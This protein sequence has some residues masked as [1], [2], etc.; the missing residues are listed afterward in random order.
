MALPTGKRQMSTDENHSGWLPLRFV[1]TISGLL[2]GERVK[3][4]NDVKQLLHFLNQE[5]NVYLDTL[6]LLLLLSR[7]ITSD[8]ADQLVTVVIIY[9]STSSPLAPHSAPSYPPCYSR[10]LTGN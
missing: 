10:R 2:L 5:I 1:Y 6:F 4:T 3:L 8:T 9:F 7:P